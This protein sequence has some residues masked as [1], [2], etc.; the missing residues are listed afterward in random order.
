[1]QTCT[2]FHEDSLLSLANR[3]TGTVDEGG[4]LA[5]DNEH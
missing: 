5:Y 1:M 2:L 4:S 3:V